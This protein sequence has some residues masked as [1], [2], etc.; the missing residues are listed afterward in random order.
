MA[1]KRKRTAGAL[2]D[3]QKFYQFLLYEATSGSLG[4]APNVSDK[5]QSMTFGEKRGLL[6]SIIKV[7]ALQR[8][9]AGD[10]EEESPFEAIRKQINASREDGDRGDSSGSTESVADA[11]DDSEEFTDEAG[12]S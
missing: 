6:D 5:P 11:S 2:K 12:E 9:V 3:A 8:Q 4:Q 10:V 7:A 1:Q